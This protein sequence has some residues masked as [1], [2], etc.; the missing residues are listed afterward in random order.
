MAYDSVKSIQPGERIRLVS[1]NREVIIRVN[2]IRRYPSF[3]SMLANEDA[4]K[5]V[6]DRSQA[7]VARVLKEIYPADR[8]RLGVLVLDIS[9]ESTPAHVQ[10]MRG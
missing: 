4:S 9:P 10:A 2:D 1:H 7:D 3:D 8:E 5:I 6:P